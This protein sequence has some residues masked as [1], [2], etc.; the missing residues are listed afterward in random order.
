[1]PLFSSIQPHFSIYSRGPKNGVHFCKSILGFARGVGRRIG[2]PPDASIGHGGKYDDDSDSA[3]C[4]RNVAW[5]TARANSRISR[6]LNRGPSI[7]SWS[8]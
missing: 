2:L 1:M 8:N 3:D 6:G 4:T 5:G 7:E